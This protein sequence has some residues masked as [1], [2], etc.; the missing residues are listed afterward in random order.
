[1]LFWLTSY[2]FVYLPTY[3]NELR[4]HLKIFKHKQPPV[5]FISLIYPLIQVSI[6][7]NNALT[8]LIFLL[9]SPLFFLLPIETFST[10]DFLFYRYR[11]QLYFFCPSL[12]ITIT[13]QFHLH[14]TIYLQSLMLHNNNK[15][16]TGFGDINEKLISL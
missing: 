14:C 12:P 3:P 9:Y 7:L 11:C 2:I 16:I 13:F 1:M 6:P 15:K 4:D 8:Y 10:V 5:K